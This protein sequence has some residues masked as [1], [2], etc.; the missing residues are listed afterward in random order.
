[1]LTLGDL[2]EDHLE[3]RCCISPKPKL[4][5]G[6]RGAASCVLAGGG[7]GAS[8]SLCSGLAEVISHLGWLTSSG[9]HSP[10]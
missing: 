5:P 3:G 2:E 7:R 1:M 8:T 10:N 6:G 4:S 9:L